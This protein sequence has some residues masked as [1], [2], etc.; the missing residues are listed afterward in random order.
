[1]SGHSHWSGIKHKKALVDSKRGQIFTKLGRAISVAARSGRGNPEFNPNL[2]L[3]IEKARSFNMPNDK[4]DNSIK[5]GLGEGAQNKLEEAEYEGLGP[6]GTMLI[7][8]AITDNKNRTV[9]DIRRLLEKHQGKMADGGISWNFKRVGIIEILPDLDRK[10]EI[11]NIAIENE[12]ADIFEKEDNSVQ[13]IS[14]LENFNSLKEIFS[15]YPIRESGLSYMPKN[16]ITLDSE[17]KVKYDKLVESL[18]EHPD[19]QEVFDN[20]AEM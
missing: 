18:I 3:A 12:A 4:I 16:P 15:H 9:S 13:I 5:K 8:K 2:R 17:Q 6:F 10:E 14:D 11:I 19:V 20:V 1:M 7:I